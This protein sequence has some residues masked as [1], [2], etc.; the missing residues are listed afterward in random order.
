MVFSI[1]ESIL[2]QYRNSF[3]RLYKGGF[4]SLVFNTR[5]SNAD[6]I[7][8][9]EA[10]HSPLVAYKPKDNNL[11]RAKDKHQEEWLRLSGEILDRIKALKAS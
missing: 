11:K 4:D 3:K 10:E 6:I 8:K 1:L 5:I 9:S 7:R 2:N